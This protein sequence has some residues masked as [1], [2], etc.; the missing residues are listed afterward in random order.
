[1]MNSSATNQIIGAHDHNSVQINVGHVNA[2][3]VY[4]GEY[5][6][7]AL[8]GVLRSQGLADAALNRLAAQKKLIRDLDAFPT[9]DKYK[10][11]KK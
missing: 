3:G 2:Q 8:S 4:N 1:M 5:T 10:T 11:E 6:T 7:F 9:S